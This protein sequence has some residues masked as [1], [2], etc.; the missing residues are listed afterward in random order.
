[1]HPRWRDGQS[2]ILRRIRRR[3]CG[4]PSSIGNAVL[5]ATNVDGVYSADPKQDKSAIR[6]D[7][8]QPSAKQCSAT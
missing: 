1:M 6:Y 8:L 5:K 3:S 4:P 2:L 7:R